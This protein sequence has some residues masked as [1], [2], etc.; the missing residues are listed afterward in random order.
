[1][2]FLLVLVA[3]AWN[4]ACIQA[5]LPFLK[6]PP[7]TPKVDPLIDD[8]V[9]LIEEAQNGLDTT[10]DDEVKSLMVEISRSRQGDQRDSLSG[11][12]ELI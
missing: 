6:Q 11:R 2:Q 9:Q 10:R 1:M 5:F 8:L 7:S 4:C 3:F 12:W